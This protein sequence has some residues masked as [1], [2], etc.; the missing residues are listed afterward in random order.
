MDAAVQEKRQQVLVM[1]INH[2]LHNLG[3]NMEMTHQNDVR[4]VNRSYLRENFTAQPET[5]Q[6]LMKMSL[7]NLNFLPPDQER[8]SDYRNHAVTPGSWTA[9]HVC[10]WMAGTGKSQV[11]SA[12]G[13]TSAR[14]DFR[15]IQ[16]H[17]I[18][19]L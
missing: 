3:G 18:R 16:L 2:F 9:N 5:A 4:I 12:S 19:T 7:K 14:L 17:L 1:E 15:S 13:G 8:A 6:N 11:I 10:W